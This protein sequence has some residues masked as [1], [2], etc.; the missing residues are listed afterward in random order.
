[1]L[2]NLIRSSQTLRFILK[3][4]RSDINLLDNEAA[5]F[6]AGNH[7]YIHHLFYYMAARFYR[8]HTSH[9]SCNHSHRHHMLQLIL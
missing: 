1:M 7:S 3:C 9:Y 6:L 5:V 2:Q 4:I 8:N